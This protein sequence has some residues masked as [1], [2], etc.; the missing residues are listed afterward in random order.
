M[1][2]IGK[3][4]GVSR[5]FFSKKTRI[6]FEIED[7]TAVAQV[8]EELRDID[9]L[10]IIAKKHRKHRSG[11]ENR[12][13]H[14]LVGLLAESLG[15][16]LPHTKNWLI[17]HYGQPLLDDDGKGFVI[18]VI[19]TR[20]REMEEL[21]DYHYTA[22]G[23]GFVGNTEFTHWQMMRGTHTYDTKE[24]A[25]IIDGACQECVNVG[26]DPRTPQEV[27]EWL[28]LWRNRNGQV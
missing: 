7:G 24:M 28:A 2:L 25:R 26:I 12:Y 11:E 9:R 23:H 1:E 14:K 13:F 10:D 17:S 6:V 3:L 21:T 5:D 16:S 27:A 8:Y 18:S 22:I 4:V 20:D 19:S 15:Y